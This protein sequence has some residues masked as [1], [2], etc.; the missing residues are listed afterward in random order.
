M[1]RAFS[2]ER[3]ADSFDLPLTVTESTLLRRLL[4]GL[5]VPTG[6]RA[7]AARL[8]VR[9]LQGEHDVNTLHADRRAERARMR[10]RAR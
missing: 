5:P 4:D 3:R 9:L 10:R 8:T 6:Q 1:S 7:L 2:A